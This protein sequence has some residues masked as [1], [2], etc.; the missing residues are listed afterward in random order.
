MFLLRFPLQL[1]LVQR[2]F[3]TCC[4]Y[5]PFSTAVV[6]PETVFLTVAV[7][8]VVA[9]VSTGA[10]SFLWHSFYSGFVLLLLRLLLFLC[11]F[12]NLCSQPSAALVRI[13]VFAPE[14]L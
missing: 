2:F 4:F 11:L 10:L 5:D 1:L 9:V 14:I 3:C 12:C 8:S 6:V 13:K 7:V